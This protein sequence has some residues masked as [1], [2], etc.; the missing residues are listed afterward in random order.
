[1]DLFFF[2]T[3]DCYVLFFTDDVMYVPLL[4]KMMRVNEKIGLINPF[5]TLELTIGGLLCTNFLKLIL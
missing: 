5:L 1:M 4:S 3:P 2:L